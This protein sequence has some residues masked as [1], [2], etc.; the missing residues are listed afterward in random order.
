MYVILYP[1]NSLVPGNILDSP[2]K[3]VNEF[4]GVGNPLWHD[5]SSLPFGKKTAGVAVPA[6]AFSLRN[7]IIPSIV[8]FS[9]SMSGFRNNRN[10][11]LDFFIPTL[12]PLENPTF[13]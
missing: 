10:L 3:Y 4:Q 1:A 9:T 7:S 2:E 5:S 13:A 12:F 6:P 11:P 8:P